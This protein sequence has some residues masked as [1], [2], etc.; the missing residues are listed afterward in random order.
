MGLVSGDSKS[1][2]LQSHRQAMPVD[3]LLNLRIYFYKPTKTHRH[4]EHC[5]GALMT[6]YHVGQRRGHFQLFFM[7]IAPSQGLCTDDACSCPPGG[8][9]YPEDI[10]E[11]LLWPGLW[12][13]QSSLEVFRRIQGIELSLWEKVGIRMKKIWDGICTVTLSVSI[14]GGVRKRQTLHSLSCCYVAHNH[15][16]SL[17][18][19]SE[20]S[21]LTHMPGDGPIQAGPAHRPWSGPSL[22]HVSL[23]ALGPAGYPGRVFFMVIVDLQ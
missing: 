17:T 19:S 8:H 9:G 10:R 6:K 18:H 5:F 16:I 20:H 11:Q 4:V 3:I 13:Y 1:Y 2:T 12:L 23:F 7:D 15:K 21:F 22:P 14:D